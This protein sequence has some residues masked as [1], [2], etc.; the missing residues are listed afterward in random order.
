MNGREWIVTAALDGVFGLAL[1]I[2]LVPVVG[3]VVV[4]AFGLLRNG[5][6]R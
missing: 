3:R 1:G 6:S 5:I 4:P 2:V